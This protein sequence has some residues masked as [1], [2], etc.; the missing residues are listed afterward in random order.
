[1]ANHQ[2]FYFIIPGKQV[3]LKRY[4][5]TAEGMIASWVERFPTTDVDEFLEEL[6]EKDSAY[7]RDLN[8][9]ATI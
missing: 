5:A 6:A 1:M 7:F 8:A 2:F 4:P 3:E 9:I